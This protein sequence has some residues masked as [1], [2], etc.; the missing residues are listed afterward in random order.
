MGAS[1]LTPAALYILL[2]LIDEER[3][4]YGIM[5]EVARLTEG[6]VR[7]SSGTLYR[8]IKQ[9]LTAGFIAETIERPDP[10]IDDE[11]RRYYRL[12]DAGRRAAEIEAARLEQVVRIARA[13]HLLHPE[14]AEGGAR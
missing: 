6:A 1:T 14:T 9:L 3:H 10:E 13:Q 5:L 7:L 4:G 11:R 12:T 2:A 8:S